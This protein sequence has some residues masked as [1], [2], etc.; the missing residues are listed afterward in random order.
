MNHLMRAPYFL[1]NSEMVIKKLKTYAFLSEYLMSST[2]YF[3]TFCSKCRSILSRQLVQ[4]DVARPAPAEPARLMAA[5]RH[6]TSLLDRL[7][8]QSQLHL[9]P[10][11]RRSVGGHHRTKVLH[12]RGRGLGSGGLGDPLLHDGGVAHLRLS[13][14]RR[15]GRGDHLHQCTIIH[16]GN[17]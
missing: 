9:R 1:I 8:S 2:L 11:H 17:R 10:V 6:G 13:H 7:S 16:C 5:H 12:D 15:A 4:L 14:H 3:V